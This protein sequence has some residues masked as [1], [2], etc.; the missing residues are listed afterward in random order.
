[1]LITALVVKPALLSWIVENPVTLAELIV[2][3]GFRGTVIVAKFCVTFV[4][5]TTPVVLVT[6]EGLVEV[7]STGP[8]V[9]VFLGRERKPRTL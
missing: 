3:I 8:D 2:V 7:E 6:N 1:M 4:P 9:M 5:P